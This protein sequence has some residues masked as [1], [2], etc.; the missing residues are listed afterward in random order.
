MAKIHASQS[1]LRELAKLDAGTY[2]I[3]GHVEPLPQPA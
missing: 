3:L 2:R 1:A